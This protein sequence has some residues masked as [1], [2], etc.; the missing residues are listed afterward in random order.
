MA[1]L[2]NQMVLSYIVYPVHL[3]QS[4]SMKLGALLI[5]L[6]GLRSREGGLSTDV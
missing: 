3:D 2:N 4:I 1:M 6:C 5:F